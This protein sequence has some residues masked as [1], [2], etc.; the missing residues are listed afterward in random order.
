MI[1][2]I[3][4]EHLPHAFR[5]QGA[6]EAYI[7]FEWDQSLRLEGKALLVEFNELR[8]VLLEAGGVIQGLGVILYNS[9]IQQ[10]FLEYLLCPG[11]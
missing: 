11:D 9:F 10:A 1:L 8:E 2:Q 6:A 7:E 4:F 3:F 5:C